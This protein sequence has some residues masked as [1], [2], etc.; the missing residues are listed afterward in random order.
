MVVIAVNEL[1]SSHW[2]TGLHIKSTCN[3]YLENSIQEIPLFLYIFP[4]Q[5]VFYNFNQSREKGVNY[6]DSV[7]S[8]AD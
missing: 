7:F 8:C 1:T 4:I 2:Y 6:T 3:N 5:I